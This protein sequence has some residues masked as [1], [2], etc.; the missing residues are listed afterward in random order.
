MDYFEEQQRLS[1]SPVMYREK[2]TVYLYVR[3]NRKKYKLNNEGICEQW[4]NDFRKLLEL[5][6]QLGIDV[7]EINREEFFSMESIT[8]IGEIN[9]WLSWLLNV[10]YTIPEKEKNKIYIF[11]YQFVF[12]KLTVYRL[13]KYTIIGYNE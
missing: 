6:Y 5:L 4:E 3:C 8:I 13:D 1:L 9:D 11:L 2:N 10:D 12:K 7:S